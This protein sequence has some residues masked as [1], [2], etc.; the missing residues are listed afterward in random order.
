MT[1]L[2]AAYFENKE[3][4]RVAHRCQCVSAANR[5][6]SDCNKNGIDAVV[7]GSI[8]SNTSFFRGNSD[9]DI[10]IMQE[11]GFSFNEIEKLARKNFGK[12]PYDLWHCHDLK[13]DVFN[14][15]MKNGVRHV[16]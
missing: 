5:F 3:N 15:V 10:C 16:N 6:L 11:N 4:R 7:F 14:E 12:L 13:T 9:V 8:V 2:K 1:G